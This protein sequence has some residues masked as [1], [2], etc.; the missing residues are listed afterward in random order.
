MTS[1]GTSA[2][3]FSSASIEPVSVISTIFASIVP[4]IPGSS[5]AVPWSASSAID[6][7]VSRI[8]VAARR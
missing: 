2:R 7:P 3:R 5:L 4:P 6:A 1:S 8:R